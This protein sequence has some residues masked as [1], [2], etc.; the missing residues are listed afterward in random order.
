[1]AQTP[2]PAGAPG[3]SFSMSNLSTADKIIIGSAGLYIIWAFFPVWYKF[4]V[5]A[6]IPGIPGFSASI[7]GFR[8]VTLIAWLLALAAVV[9]ALLPAFGVRMQVSFKPAMV[10][11]GL[12]GLATLLTLLGLVVKPTGFGISFGIFVAVILALA[13]LYGA[14]MKFQQAPATTMPPFAPPPP[15]PA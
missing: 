15:P 2:P 12:A 13:W 8:G 1:M 14:Y 4:S 11:L 6:G 9:W 5:S 10:D 7:N 3:P